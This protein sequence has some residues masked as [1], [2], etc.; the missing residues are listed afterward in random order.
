MMYNA[1]TIQEMIMYCVVMCILSTGKG[2]IVIDQFGSWEKVFF[3]VKS[4]T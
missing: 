1:H 3:K 2:N 4:T